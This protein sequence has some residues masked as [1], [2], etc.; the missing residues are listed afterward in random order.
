MSSL[1][2]LDI[3]ARSATTLPSPMVRNAEPEVAKLIDVSVCIGCKACQVAC[4]QWNDLRDEIGHN[5]GVYDNPADLSA[6]SW[7][8]MRFS[9]VETKKE[10]EETRLEWLIRKDGCMHCADPGCL[11]ACPSPGAIVQYANGIVDFI[12]ENCIG[13]GN[14]VTGCPF[15]IPRISKKDSKAYKCTLCSDRV[16]VGLEPACVKACPT[17]A[18]QF[19]TKTDMLEYAAERVVDLKERGYAQA[20]VY[21][22]PGVGGTH[23]MYVLQHADQPGLYHGLAADPRISPWV[24][25]W[26]GVAKPLA[27]ASMI[28]AAL[29][30][31]FHYVKVGPSEVEE[32]EPESRGDARRD[33]GETAAVG[34]PTPEEHRT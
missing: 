7:T 29:V 30:G 9:E 28:G 31:F 13:C 14:C 2:S 3:A 27:L 34:R 20:G 23:V 11:K 19:G 4:M 18:I 24:S 1:Q 17:G 15:D 22:P 26:K 21:D 25:L 6:E 16:T 10:N 12:E 5:V 8:V 32:D 33:A